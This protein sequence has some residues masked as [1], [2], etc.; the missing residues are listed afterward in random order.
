MPH[1]R[2]TTSENKFSSASIG[3]SCA[4]S[5]LTDISVSANKGNV[6]S[7]ESVTSDL[8]EVSVKDRTDEREKI[9]IGKLRDGRNVNV[10]ERAQ[11]GILL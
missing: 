3:A 5:G 1:T 9:K 8:E 2:I 11:K 4:L 7:K 6:D 10:R